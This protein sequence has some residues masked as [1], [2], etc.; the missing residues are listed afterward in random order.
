MSSSPISAE[1]VEIARRNIATINH[2][3]KNEHTQA[4]WWSSLSQLEKTVLCMLAKLPTASR[5]LMWGNLSPGDRCKIRA[6]MNR[7]VSIRD[8][9]MRTERAAR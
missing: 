9:Y 7:A 1:L 5:G 3:L 6:A 4:A 8:S 2:I